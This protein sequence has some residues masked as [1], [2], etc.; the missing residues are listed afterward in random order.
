VG[1]RRGPPRIKVH[2]GTERR[3]V[4]RRG[5]RKIPVRRRTMVVLVDLTWVRGSV[6]MEM[7]PEPSPELAA[8]LVVKR[9][10]KVSSWWQAV[11]G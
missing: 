2:S 8:M 7:L 3:Q 5:R 6:V 1:R 4:V 9:L 10:Q 11:G